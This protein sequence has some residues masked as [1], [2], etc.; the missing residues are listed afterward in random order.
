VNLR[1]PNNSYES[2][3]PIVEKLFVSEFQTLGRVPSD[4]FEAVHVLLA[5]Q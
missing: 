1:S 5:V 2:S 3:A 4:Q